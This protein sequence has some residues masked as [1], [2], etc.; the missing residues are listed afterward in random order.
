YAVLW[1]AKAHD[2]A[3]W[4][5]EICKDRLKQKPKIAG[6]F[7]SY[8]KEYENCYLSTL[9]SMAKS[10][11]HTYVLMDDAAYSGM[12]VVDSIG[13]IMKYYRARRE[14][15]PEFKVIPRII[16][17]IPY[18]GEYYK[19]R[20]KEI[21][22]TPEEEANLIIVPHQTIPTLGDI[23]EIAG[24]ADPSRKDLGIFETSA[25]LSKALTY[26]DHKKPDGISFPADFSLFV[27]NSEPPYHTEGTQYYEKEKADW[28]AYLAGLGPRSGWRIPGPAM[29]TVTAPTLAPVALQLES[30]A[31]LAG[32]ATGQP[33]GDAG[34][35]AK[36]FE[37][38]IP[39]G[40]SVELDGLIEAVGAANEIGLTVNTVRTTAVRDNGL[41]TSQD[42]AI[43]I[44][45]E[46][47]DVNG[48]KVLVETKAGVSTN[49][50]TQ[51]LLDLIYTEITRPHMLIQPSIYLFDLAVSSNPQDG[52]IDFNRRDKAPNIKVHINSFDWVLTITEV[53]D[54]ALKFL[55]GLRVELSKEM[56]N[57]KVAAAT[58][59]WQAAHPKK[60]AKPAVAVADLRLKAAQGELDEVMLQDGYAK[61]GNIFLT[62]RTLPALTQGQ[63]PDGCI[64]IQIDGLD[65]KKGQLIKYAYQDSTIASI[66]ALQ[67]MKSQLGPEE[68]SK[69]RFMDAWSGTGI[70]G[71]VA[72]RLGA[73]YVLAVEDYKDKDEPGYID[74]AKANIQ[75]QGLG[76]IEF[77][78]D[79]VREA[80]GKGEQEAALITKAK[81][82]GVNVIMVNHE[83]GAVVGATVALLPQLPNVKYLVLGGSSVIRGVLE[84]GEPGLEATTLQRKV[85]N[86]NIG[87]EVV[88]DNDM[89]AKF[90]ADVIDP[91]EALVYNVNKTPVAPAGLTPAQI[92]EQKAAAEKER[93]AKAE[94]AR[95]AQERAQKEAEQQRFLEEQARKAA[96][97]RAV[98][99]IKAAGSIARVDE[100]LGQNGAIKNDAAVAAAAESTKKNLAVAI[101]ALALTDI[102][103]ATTEDGVKSILA[104]VVNKKLA[105][106]DPASPE[107][108]TSAG[109]EK[110]TFINKQITRIAEEKAA[111]ERAREAAAR[112]EETARL[113]AERIKAEEAAARAA[114]KSAKVL[115]RQAGRR[116]APKG[117]LVDIPIPKLDTQVLEKIRKFADEASPVMQRLEAAAANTSPILK[118]MLMGQLGIYSNQFI[119][120]TAT[121]QQRREALDGIVSLIEPFF[122]AIPGITNKERKRMFEAQRAKIMAVT[123]E[124][125]LLDALLP[126]VF[127]VARN[128][129]QVTLD[130]RAYQTQILCALAIHFGVIAELPTGQ[131]K[132]ISIGFP[133][134][135]NAITQQVHVK[136]RSYGKAKEDAEAN[137]P[138]YSAFGHVVGLI[139]RDPE[140]TGFLVMG[141]DDKPAFVKAEG[142]T[143]EVYESAR[144]IYGQDTDFGFDWLEDNQV[145]DQALKK[146]MSLKRC[147]Q[148]VDEADG[149]LVDAFNNQLRMAGPVAEE[150]Y[151]AFKKDVG[152]A[153]AIIAN[154]IKTENSL[155]HGAFEDWQKKRTGKAE[156]AKLYNGRYFEVKV[157][158]T[159]ETV[160]LTPEGVDFI[161]AQVAQQG[162]GVENLLD[163]TV[164]ARYWFGR[165]DNALKAHTVWNRDG[166][167]IVRDGKVVITDKLTGGR[168]EGQRLEG[169]LHEA[170]EAKEGVEIG[171]PTEE[172]DSVSSA[173]LNLQ[174]RK[175]AGTT[176][177][178]ATE[179]D[180]FRSTY[181]MDVY[182]V[183][184]NTEIIREHRPDKLFKTRFE[185]WDAMVKQILADHTAGI[186]ILACVGTSIPHA[187][188]LGGLL[189]GKMSRDEIAKGLEIVPDQAEQLMR[190]VKGSLISGVRV[191]DAKKADQEE[192]IVAEAGKEGAVTIATNMAGRGTDI[193]IDK[194]VR[195]KGLSVLISE[196]SADPRIDRQVEGRTGRQ[197]DPGTVQYFLSLEDELIIKYAFVDRDK[198]SRVV[199]SEIDQIRELLDKNDIEAALEMVLGIQAKASTEA[200]AARNRE[201]RY[202][203]P[204]DM[205]LDAVDIMRNHLLEGVGLVPALGIMNWKKVYGEQDGREFARDV[206][207][208]VGFD[209]E[210]VLDNLVEDINAKL[211]DQGSYEQAL[212]IAKQILI[213]A[214]DKFKGPYGQIKPEIMNIVNS[215]MPQTED[216][217]YRDYLLELRKAFRIF[218]ARVER[219][220]MKSVNSE[221]A[222]KGQVEAFAD[223][224]AGRSRVA[225][226]L[227]AGADMGVKLSQQ[228]AEQVEAAISRD[229][230]AVEKGVA[231][232]LDGIMTA[233]PEAGK[234]VVTAI[235]SSLFNVQPILSRFYNAAG[236]RFDSEAFKKFVISLHG[237]MKDL[238]I[239]LLA[240]PALLQE[241]VSVD[242]NGNTIVK[243]AEG[244]AALMTGKANEK[245]AQLPAV[246]LVGQALSETRR[247]QE[248]IRAIEGGLRDAGISY[249]V[250]EKDMG[251][252]NENPRGLLVRVKKE[253]P[254][255]STETRIKNL[256]D[257]IARV[258]DMQR[259]GYIFVAFEKGTSRLVTRRV[260]AE[261]EKM[262][263]EG[264][265][266]DTPVT[267]IEVDEQGRS[268]AKGREALELGVSGRLE[269]A[270]DIA[271][272]S[273]KNLTKARKAVRL[274]TLRTKWEIEG[275]MR[276]VPTKTGFVLGTALYMF[277]GQQQKV[278]AS[279]AIA[280]MNTQ[281]EALKQKQETL[282]QQY[283][284]GQISV[285]AYAAQAGSIL[286][287]R[288]NALTNALIWE[289][290]PVLK[291]HLKQ[292]IDAIRDLRAKV[293]N[294]MTASARAQQM[295]LMTATNVV[296]Q[297]T[298]TI[299]PPAAPPV[300]KPT[301]VQAKLAAQPAA[302][303]TPAAQPQQTE[304]A[305][306]VQQLLGQMGN[307]LAEAQ[308]AAAA[309]AQKPTVEGL[310]KAAKLFEEIVRQFYEAAALDS[311]LIDPKTKD[312]E[313]NRKGA[314]SFKKE[315][316]GLRREIQRL[317]AA[318]AQPKPVAPMT[319]TPTVPA[320]Q[321]QVQAGTLMAQLSSMNRETV[322]SGKTV[323]VFAYDH[324]NFTDADYQLFAD[325]G[326][327]GVVVSG[328]HDGRVMSADEVAN[329][330]KTFAAKGI[331]L[332]VVLGDPSWAYD[333]KEDGLKMVRQLAENL[334]KAKKDLA[335]TPAAAAI[336]GIVW[337]VEPHTAGAR[338]NFNW[339]NC[340]IVTKEAEAIAKKNGLDFNV[341]LP[342][343]AGQTKTEDGKT[344]VG[345]SQLRKPDNF[346]YPILIMNYRTDANMAFNFA[347][348]LGDTVPH[349]F[350][351]EFIPGETNQVSFGAG[352]QVTKA[353][354]ALASVKEKYEAARN[355]ARG[356]NY[357]GYFL[358]AENISQLRAI[359]AKLS[360]AQA[361]AEA[362][363]PKA[364]E[365]VTPP[366]QAPPAAVVTPVAPPA[367]KPTP[368]PTP[369][370]APTAPAPATPAQA[371]PAELSQDVRKLINQGMEEGQDRLN[372]LTPEQRAKFAELLSGLEI[373][374]AHATHAAYANNGILE[375]GDLGM[376]MSKLT[377][378]QK[379]LEVIQAALEIKEDKAHPAATNTERAKRVALELIQWEQ[380]LAEQ[381]VTVKPTSAQPAPTPA[382]IP[383]QPKAGP[384][385][386]EAPTPLLAAQPAPVAAPAQVTTPPAVTITTETVEGKAKGLWARMSNIGIMARATFGERRYPDL[387]KEVGPRQI[388]EA[389]TRQENELLKDADTKEKAYK[390][391]TRDKKEALYAMVLAKYN[392][393]KHYEDTGRISEAL[394]VISPVV[395]LQDFDKNY[396]PWMPF[397]GCPKKIEVWRLEHRLILEQGDFKAV[398]EN[399]RRLKERGFSPQDMNR[400]ASKGLKKRLLTPQEGVTRILDAQG[401]LVITPAAKPSPGITVPGALGTA[402]ERAEKEPSVPAYA[403]P[404]PRRAPPVEAEK[405]PAPEEPLRTEQPV[406]AD[407]IPIDVP[408]PQPGKP[409]KPFTAPPVRAVPILAGQTR[410]SMPAGQ[411]DRIT[412]D[413]K[414]LSKEIPDGQR[415]PGE[416]AKITID[417]ERNIRTQD[418]SKR[419]KFNVKCEAAGDFF[420]IFDVARRGSRDRVTTIDIGGK[421]IWVE[422]NLDTKKAKIF[423]YDHNIIRDKI[424]SVTQE[425][426]PLYVVDKQMRLKVD[427]S[428]DTP[429]LIILKDTEAENI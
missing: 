351:M 293:D 395:N 249:E 59:T 411:G 55:K 401:V 44:V 211:G 181:Q 11:I 66:L 210:R 159:E 47:N 256:V 201:A 337:D 12:N 383:A 204:I 277:G 320:T 34:M 185:K 303:V 134:I 425:G 35:L 25:S 360:A 1:G 418:T 229:M 187:E 143:K 184:S 357:R 97:Q 374:G 382:P 321:P 258:K 312:G 214:L 93:A 223:Q 227:K 186:P 384:P 308:E 218:F 397:N 233:Q 123:N 215:R 237:Q 285:M 393:A 335:N 53:E 325:M 7:G 111:V 2:S 42:G 65:L 81:E 13:K 19:T 408:A 343:W 113:E 197:G 272:R 129:G 388:T 109:T 316:A 413:P 33:T 344:Q 278:N 371:K 270:R 112:A 412:D 387:L 391:A 279:E 91:W 175:T 294:I 404:A 96:V 228:M 255:A 75:A 234:A 304:K 135:L 267:L 315:A 161:Q 142:G 100:I 119:D 163:E 367:A 212:F 378:K 156:D 158:R 70:L 341:V 106:V 127:A 302:P 299:A 235:S 377:D 386:A 20:L 291:S 390:N 67:K 180:F 262:A 117:K 240:N 39:K 205:Q 251:F 380:A 276:K 422:F 208:S 41:Y 326:V 271:V 125:A 245:I 196:R 84:P 60:P 199:Y 324:W 88:L 82:Q 62:H 171:K 241:R 239:M 139:S 26:F 359:A 301:P 361:P 257:F 194:E 421:K 415:K 27:D 43:P 273:G 90:P 107:K 86:L 424:V 352:N 128:V 131:G 98:N 18:M 423:Q 417:G 120:A 144:I 17:S 83:L 342:F 339:T 396:D 148:I 406:Q 403:I 8:K 246:E 164:N 36:G 296:S 154:L 264:A 248:N 61:I 10:G 177:T 317:E 68:F 31:G 242:E 419:L 99:D 350:G 289:K 366:A 190:T 305:K 124:D 206:A 189:S 220:A 353:P 405:K 198:K 105:T 141:K 149:L 23:K 110:I 58:R 57:K 183:P 265:L 73:G 102:E 151:E 288:T 202:N 165:L 334:N 108:I 290:S 95:L 176:A 162:L 345:A 6:Y 426:D 167:Y 24:K 69:L 32:Y 266:K 71:I 362:A 188:A 14:A 54:P 329:L 283:R 280:K 22:L 252:G 385:S 370:P 169:G 166:K 313:N 429:T 282:A 51:N 355:K 328:Y 52:T 333:K 356:Q 146:Q 74:R 226:V 72:A 195:K 318:K 170:I 319:L 56:F 136:A 243:G 250:F 85:S 191:L 392:L 323:A 219:E 130:K 375:I 122:Y 63:L 50:L 310:D 172:K 314:E 216:A 150:N 46:F 78:E 21:G 221:L 37:F 80:P 348:I 192:Q 118:Q 16:V 369:K 9:N 379:L 152:I 327:S 399:Y 5:Y 29:V 400:F 346:P 307:R 322:R 330:A 263:K 287:A 409:A 217:R 363:V 253:S 230:A 358:H 398:T 236:A 4:V 200:I 137:L 40:T 232:A 389:D 286:D 77:E 306:Q 372:L 38:S 45:I 416:K 292:Q 155:T 231:E 94:Q 147:F 28:E 121:E 103:R 213:K 364:P 15:D 48:R 174:Y 101:V 407:A 168:L 178:A 349:M 30:L 247:D 410:V 275:T 373:S 331:K 79:V 336:A 238:T 225:D 340:I 76:N 179:R 138:L 64:L 87:L 332:K 284:A 140:K 354:A 222:T 114:A 365:A 298:L 428:G 126:V 281:D 261:V 311:T 394:A 203:F 3:R 381:P 224:Q 254:G 300:A 274:A 268:A 104:D 414:E 260:A 116:E 92:A 259:I 420:F 209:P 173:R 338:W 309:A 347:G 244:L 402:A 295:T 368:I 427:L 157:D 133:A 376:T 160:S 193:K 297:A 269:M 89:C 182:V 153:D 49:Q 145:M 115:K 207:L 132:T